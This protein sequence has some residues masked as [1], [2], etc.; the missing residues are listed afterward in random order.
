[1]IQ[2]QVGDVG[3][4]HKWITKCPT[5]WLQV[6][7]GDMRRNSEKSFVTAWETIAGTW[8]YIDVHSWSLIRS[9]IFPTLPYLCQSLQRQGSGGQKKKTPIGMWVKMEDRCG[10]TDVNV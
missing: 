3:V 8:M 7:N 1:M 4:S 9:F 10:T 5:G 2:Q 6:T